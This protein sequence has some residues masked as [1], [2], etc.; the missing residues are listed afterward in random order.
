LNLRAA[1]YFK[2]VVGY[3]AKLLVPEL[4]ALNLVVTENVKKYSQLLT[5]I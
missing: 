5:K 1:D 3:T 2:Q 4:S